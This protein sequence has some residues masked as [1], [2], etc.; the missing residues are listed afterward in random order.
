MLRRAA[1]AAV[2][3]AAVLVPAAHADD[4]P[5]LGNDPGCRGSLLS[6]TVCATDNNGAGGAP[7]GLPGKP[8]AAPGKPAA[9]PVCTYTKLV[10]QPPPDNYYW[11]G[12]QGTKGA[13]Y[14]FHCSDRQGARTVFIP[15]AAAPPAA[16]AVNPEAVA[17]QAIDSVRLDGPQVASPRAAGTYVIGM[18]MWMWAKPSAS[19]FGPITATATAGGTTVTATAKVTSTKWNM[20]DGAVITC[21]GPGTPYNASYGKTMSPDCGHKYTRLARPLGQPYKGTATSTWTIDWQV[22]GGTG[23]TGQFTETRATPFTVLI[24]E[25]QVLNVPPGQR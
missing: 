12:Q 4:G 24:Q 8:A 19:T 1:V 5:A 10:P 17:R 3:L 18:P 13:V 2:V 15:D 6:V 20:G 25:V 16:P 14:G 21:Y 7:G 23:E 22:T 9:K 11:K